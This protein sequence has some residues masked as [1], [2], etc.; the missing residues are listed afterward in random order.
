MKSSHLAILLLAGVLALAGCGPKDK[1]KNENEARP[2]R[3]REL[4][5]EAMA[6]L[7]KGRYD[8]S[9]LLFNVI[10]TTYADSEFLPFAKLAIADSFYREGGA[11]ALEQAVGGYKDFAQ[12]FPTHPLTCDVKL[13]IA[14]AHMRQMNA[15]NRDWTKAKQ[16]EF[17]LQATMQTCQSTPLKPQI[18]ENLVQVQQWL[19]LHEL[20]IADFYFGPNR[21]AFKAAESRYRDVVKNYPK[22]TYRD[23]ALFRLGQSLIEQ[24]QPEEAAQYFAEL[25][26][27]IPNSEFAGEAREFLEK[28]GK[29]VP[30]PANDDPAP[31]RPGKMGKLGLILGFNDLTISK[32]G[33]LIGEEGEAKEDAVER[34]QKPVDAIGAGGT[35]SI[36]ANTRGPVATPAAGSESSNPAAAPEATQTRPRVTSTSDGDPKPEEKKEEKKK[37]EKK[38]KSGLGKLFR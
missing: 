14:Q 33:V 18:E 12:Y 23:Q 15:Y 8:E 4:Y 20:G 16:A 22:F 5:A 36:R 19:G 28:L 13:K 24:E 30:E 3:D 37:D 10:I 31:H 29:P 17:Q 9:R 27:E 25:V 6:K 7:K 21:R 2:D 35:G 38:K 26:R 1:V 34:L 32:A 11:T